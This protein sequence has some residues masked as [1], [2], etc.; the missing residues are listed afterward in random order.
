MKVSELE[1]G[2]RDTRGLS[3]GS[4]TRLNANASIRLAVHS[5]LFAPAHCRDHLVSRAFLISDTATTADH[6]KVATPKKE[7]SCFGHRTKP[8]GP[9]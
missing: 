8:S 1:Q 3:N 5:A 9:A 6:A 2:H 7:P 4:C